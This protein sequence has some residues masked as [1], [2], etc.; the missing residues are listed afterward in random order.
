[1]PLRHQSL[2]AWQRADDLFIRLHHLVRQRFP[3]IERFEL[4]SQIRRAAY[5]V[6]ANIVEGFARRS[7]K[8]RLNFLNISEAS[9]A[10]VWYGLHVAKRLDYISPSEFDDLERALNQVG[11]PLSGLIRATKSEQESTEY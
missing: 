4:A 10:E 7:T 2:I 1:M 3:S 6:P 9:L 5:S 8:A 11:A